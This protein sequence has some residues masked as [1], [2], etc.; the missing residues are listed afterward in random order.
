M[1][2]L[3]SGWLGMGAILDFAAFE[4]YV[5][6]F[7]SEDVESVTNYVPNAVSKAWLAENIPLFECPD[8]EVE[9]V[10]Y[11]RWWVFRKHIKATPAGFVI[12]E[13]LKPVRHAGP[14][15]TISCAVGHHLAEGRWLH[16]QRYLREYILFWLRGENGGPQPHFHRYSSWFAAAVFDWY[17][18][19]G[20]RE[21]VTGLLPDLIADYRQWEQERLLT[22]GLFWQFDVRDGM[23]ES[24]SGSRTNKNARPSINSY[25]Y[26]NAR[27]IAALARLSGQTEWAVEF[28]RKAERLRELI[29]TELWDHE[30]KFFKVRLEDGRLSDAREAIGFIPWLFDAVP[31]ED[32]YLC[33]WRQVTDPAGFKAPFGL[34]TAERRHPRFRSHGIGRCEWDGAVWPFAT[35]QT[36]GAMAKVLRA[37]TQS[38]VA[39][40]DYF[41]AFLDYVRAQRAGG[42][43]YIGEYLDETSGAWINGRDDRSRHYNHSTFADVLITGVVGVVPTPGDLVVIDPLV[44]PGTWDWFCLDGMR[45]RGST[46]AVV[47]DRTGTRYGRGAGLMVFLNGERVAW[48]PELGRLV[49]SLSGCARAPAQE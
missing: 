46:L 43:P 29:L 39:R 23:E 1:F 10:Y 18:V 35:V 31:F 49:F 9:E 41:D 6:R 42:R 30:A 34:T 40:R 33:A 13:F 11:F 7:N 37:E 26:G 32:E 47:W 14:Y 28:D 21:F 27:A 12:T 8:P 22:N 44:P 5:N 25:M 36:L 2:G 3:T 38:H 17:L 24:I 4:H 20:D 16:E 19:T 45:Y 48:R 15:N